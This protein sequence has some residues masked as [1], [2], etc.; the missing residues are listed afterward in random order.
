MPHKTTNGSPKAISASSS[1]PADAP[2]GVA[3][4]PEIQAAKIRRAK[5][6]IGGRHRPEPLILSPW[7]T[8]FLEHERKHGQLKEIEPT[9]EALQDITDWLNLQAHYGGHMIAWHRTGQG[10]LTVLAVGADEIEALLKGLSP[11]EV[12]EV[13]I[14]F[15]DPPVGFDRPPSTVSAP[16]S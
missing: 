16:S 14:D 6:I 12:A 9:E 8:E 2:G 11:E 13:V 3:L 10:V 1:Q 15:P 5:E 7:V 4:S